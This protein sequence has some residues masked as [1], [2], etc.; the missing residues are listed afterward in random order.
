MTRRVK[1]WRFHTFVSVLN[2]S[3]HPLLLAK[4]IGLVENVNLHHVSCPFFFFLK[5]LKKENGKKLW[6][7]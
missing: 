5:D 3:V 2:R 1:M 4:G 7:V 6:L